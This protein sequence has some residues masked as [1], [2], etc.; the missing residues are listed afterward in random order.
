MSSLTGAPGRNSGIGT[1][2]A[3]AEIMQISQAATW[4]ERT[5][6]GARLVGEYGGGGQRMLAGEAMSPVP[7]ALHSRGRSTPYCA[8][9]WK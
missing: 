3:G 2:V 1:P 7:V 9:G 8:S 5:V 4:A 6:V